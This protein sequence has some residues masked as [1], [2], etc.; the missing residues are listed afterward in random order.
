MTPASINRELAC[1]KRMFNVARKGLIMRKGGIPAAN[2][3]A[4]VSLERERNER[5]RVL[6]GDEFRCLYNLQYLGFDRCS[7][8][9]TTLACARGK[10]GRSAG[11][12]WI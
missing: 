9:P 8:S 1:L 6:S 4:M 11:A 3:M 7:W 12:R 2:P 5:G 10:S